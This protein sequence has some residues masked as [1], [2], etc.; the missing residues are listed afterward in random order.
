MLEKNRGLLEA[1]HYDIAELTVE[2]DGLW[3]S[4]RRKNIRKVD[5]ESEKAREILGFYFLLALEAMRCC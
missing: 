5:D 3:G 1:N 4:E 2:M